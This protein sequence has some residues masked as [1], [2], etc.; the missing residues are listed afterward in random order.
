MN[1]LV[2]I[3]HAAE[4]LQFFLWYRDYVKRF[5]EANTSDTR[6]SPEWTAAMEDEAVARIKKDAVE[7]MRLQSKALGIFKGTDFEKGPMDVVV[8]NTD[9]FLTPPDTPSVQDA[10]SVFSGSQ[11]SSFR[12]QAQDAFTAAGATLPCPYPYPC[13]SP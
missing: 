6:L 3:E 2:Y 8:A 4:N 5:D 12:T 10:P 7:K 9:P 11:V 13:P 1:Y